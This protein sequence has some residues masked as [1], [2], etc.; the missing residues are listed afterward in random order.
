MSIF[1]QVPLHVKQFV[2][3]VDV[4]DLIDKGFILSWLAVNLIKQFF[5]GES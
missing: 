2:A 4:I 5:L 1:A 3:S